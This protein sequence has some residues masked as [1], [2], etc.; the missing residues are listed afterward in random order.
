MAE[1]LT[2]FLDDPGPATTAGLYVLAVLGILLPLYKLRRLGLVLV[3]YAAFIFPVAVTLSRILNATVSGE[4]ANLWWYSPWALWPGPNAPLLLIGL[5]AYQITFAWC[6]S[7]NPFLI[8]DELAGI[9]ALGFAIG[10][11]GCVA[12]QCCAPVGEWFVGLGLLLAVLVWATPPVRGARTAVLAIGFGAMTVTLEL[13]RYT[14]IYTMG[15]VPVK[16]VSGAMLLV[17]ASLATLWFW[18]RRPVP[19]LMHRKQHR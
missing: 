2:E 7:R 5:L 13:F 6:V 11:T 10:R 15:G 18:D 16:L 14:P 17:G 4:W 1:W 9:T 3:V 8:S 19:A 12:N